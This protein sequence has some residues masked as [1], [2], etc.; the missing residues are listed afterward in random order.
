M[1]D[2]PTEIFALAIDN[3]GGTGI[4]L[5][6]THRLAMQSLIDYCAEFI[7]GFVLIDDHDEDIQNS[8][9]EQM[10]AQDEWFVIQSATV[11]T[12]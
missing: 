7:D 9:S 8:I 4:S 10:A 6:A 12:A 11:Q 1:T 2:T 5:H 3:D